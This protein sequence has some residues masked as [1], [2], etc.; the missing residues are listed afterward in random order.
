MAP[1]DFNPF[2]LSAPKR[3]QKDDEPTKP[4]PPKATVRR[5]GIGPLLHSRFSRFFVLVGVLFICGAAGYGAELWWLAR[6][7]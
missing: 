3:M 4:K 7:K 2:D 1:D 5:V 6:T